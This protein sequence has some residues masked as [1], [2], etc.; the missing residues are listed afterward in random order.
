MGS[1][2]RPSSSR[3]SGDHFWMRNARLSLAL[4]IFPSSRRFA[5]SSAF[6]TPVGS[7]TARCWNYIRNPFASRGTAS[8]CLTGRWS[9]SFPPEIPA[10]SFTCRLPPTWG[11][12]RIFARALRIKTGRPTGAI[13]LSL[14]RF[15]PKNALMTGSRVRRTIS[16]G[17][18]TA[19]ST[20]SYWCMGA[21]S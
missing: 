9:G 5:I 18:S 14:A 17:T 13:S 3:S 2:P 11:R 20:P 16:W 7:W 1:S 12:C 15:I 19:S 10:G 4:I 21:V 6:P 8:S